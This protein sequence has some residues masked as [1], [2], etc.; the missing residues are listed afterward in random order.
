MTPTV[1]KEGM[2]KATL[3]S[4]EGHVDNTGLLERRGDARLNRGESAS[5]SV[6]LFFDSG[7]S[8]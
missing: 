3:D 1:E 2:G 5:P 4:L 8:K 6:L 7:G